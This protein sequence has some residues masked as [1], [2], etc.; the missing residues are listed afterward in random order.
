MSK[1]DVLVLA[2]AKEH[3]QYARDGVHLT[4][5]LTAAGFK[6]TQTA[7]PGE[8][9]NLLAGPN[10]VVVL[11]TFGEYLHDDDVDA[12]VE[13]VRD[14][15]GLVGV[16][17]AIVTNPSSDALGKLLGARIIKGFIGEH[18][19]VVSDLSHPLAAGI[20]PFHMDDELYVTQK[21]SDYN[22]FLV[23]RYEGASHPM[24]WSRTDGH[25]R[26]VYLANGHTVQGLTHS[27]FKELL[28][29]SVQ[30]VGEVRA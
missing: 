26:V 19:V 9:K 10:K 30:F 25:G 16:H 2:G 24:A 20:K 3:P 14:G 8:L 21:Q 15:N 7:D 22:P 18:D 1:P 4:A 29:R 5:A 17:T 12:L 13:F 28:V 11:Y 27:T 23:T 6:T